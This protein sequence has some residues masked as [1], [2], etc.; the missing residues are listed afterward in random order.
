M[1]WKYKSRR[2][3]Q[4]GEKEEEVEEDGGWKVL[5]YCNRSH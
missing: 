5:V 4:S 3:E 2:I 1:Y